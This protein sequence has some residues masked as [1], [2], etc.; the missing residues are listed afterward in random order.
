MNSTHFGHIYVHEDH[1]EHLLLFDRPLELLECLEPREGLLDLE[2]LVER[3]ERLLEAVDIERGVVDDENL[4]SLLRK[5]FREGPDLLQDLGYV[6][7]SELLLILETLLH[8]LQRG[9]E[10]VP[11]GQPVVHLVESF[12]AELR[13]LLGAPVDILV[14]D[15]ALVEALHLVKL[16]DDALAVVKIGVV[17]DREVLLIEKI[18]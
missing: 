16:L 7:F 10:E 2:V 15:L 3:L 6:E 18:E 8:R 4:E 14:L 1:V 13:D 17:L 12:A 5:G 11:G 9:T